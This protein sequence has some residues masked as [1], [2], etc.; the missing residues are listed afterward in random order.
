MN[1]RVPIT[2]SWEITHKCNRKCLHCYVNSYPERNN[3]ISLENKTIILERLFTAGISSINYIGGEPTL[4]NGFA[5]LLNLTNNYKINFSFNTNACDLSEDFINNLSQWQ[6]LT[7]IIISLEDIDPKNNDII[8]G[9]D[10]WRQTINFIN[11]VNPTRKYKLLLNMT[12]NTFNIDRHPNDI[13]H[14]IYSLGV[15]QVYFTDLVYNSS[16]PTKLR[17]THGQAANFILRLFLEGG[18]K[19]QESYL[20]YPLMA[21]CINQI[22]NKKI[23][24]AYFRGCKGAASEYRI[25]PTGKLVPCAYFTPTSLS[26]NFHNNLINDPFDK[27]IQESS[28]ADFRKDKLVATREHHCNKCSYW[29]KLCRPC[30]I[31]LSHNP[32]TRNRCQTF[33]ENALKI[34]TCAT[35]KQ[36]SPL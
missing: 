32:V 27:I 20:V 25:E 23:V 10:S 15:D 16:I 34:S 35:R 22:A 29:Y 6:H 11:K 9:Q 4:S 12:L 3:D 5:K 26:R 13:L 31:S 21:D 17:Y 8:R 2:I 28:F 19:Y 24:E 33:I 36:L 14:F 18:A 1:P 30:P 7:C